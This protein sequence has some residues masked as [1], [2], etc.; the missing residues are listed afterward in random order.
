MKNQT[1]T[2]YAGNIHDPVI[3]EM[4]QKRDVKLKESTLKNAKHFAKRNLPAPEGDKLE[5]FTADTKA[6]YEK[7]ASDIYYHLQ[8]S[9][10]FPEA[11]MDADYFRDKATKIENEIKEKNAQNLTDEFELHDFD[12][13]SIP[14]RIRWAIIATLILTIGDTIY[15]TKSF[16]VTGE[17]FLFALI[18]AICISS[19]VL[20]FS[21]I[22]PFL[23]KAAKNNL[24][25]IL[26]V[27]GS[28]LLIIGVFIAL[29]IFR[30]TYL[31][32]HGIHINPSYFVMINLFFFTVSA[33]LSFF[34]LPSWTEIKQ[35]ALLLK[36]HYAVKKRKR[37]IENLKAELDKIKSTILERTKLRIRITHLSNYASER[38]RKMYWEAMGLF[39]T[40]NLTYRS[41]NITPDCF[42]NVLPEPD[43][44]NLSITIIDNKIEK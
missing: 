14:S 26:I 22:V 17:N 16:Q 15:N 41:D 8:P 5:H 6:G 31:E 2:K 18:L 21:H 10:H 43:I 29:A 23:Y 13:S 38:I 39:K 7:L 32:R 3:E 30:S 25:R 37:E 1:I 33:L 34:V 4:I 28:F 44:D 36:T 24:Q 20:M 27:L 19:G 40:T 9:A 42:S 11:K 12:Q 35:N